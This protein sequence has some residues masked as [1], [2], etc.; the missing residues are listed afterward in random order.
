MKKRPFFLLEV[1]IALSLIA[2][3][4]MVMV[5]P[6]RIFVNEA[7]DIKRLQYYRI[8]EDSFSEVKLLLIN[9]EISWDKVA[10][11]KN[12]GVCKPI[13]IGGLYDLFTKDKLY[14]FYKVWLKEEKD[15]NNV[16]YGLLN[17]SILVEQDKTRRQLYEQTF[18]LTVKKKAI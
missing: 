1:L 9:G 4:L 16:K 14:V 3:F 12:D 8:C 6:A 15:K 11:S 7:R 2:I 13:D 10:K 18:S 17:I 5:T